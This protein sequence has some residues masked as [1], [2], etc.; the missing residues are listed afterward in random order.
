[1]T[2]NHP[3]CALPRPANPDDD[4]IKALSIKGLIAALRRIV[5]FMFK[6]GKLLLGESLTFSNSCA[7]RAFQ[8]PDGC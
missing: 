3:A 2:T 7:H 1:M 6:P 5:L 4:G 8:V